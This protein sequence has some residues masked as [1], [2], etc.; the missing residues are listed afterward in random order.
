[1][2]R[3]RT[4]CEL[5]RV[6]GVDARLD[7]PAAAQRRDWPVWMM[8]QVRE[9]DFVLVVASPAYRLRA[10]GRSSPGAGRGVQFEASLIREEFYRNSTIGTTKFLPVL[11][12]GCSVADVPMFLSPTAA[13]C[14]RIDEV[15]PSGIEDLYRVL[16]GQPREIPGPLGPV[17]A[18]PPRPTSH[19]SRLDDDVPG[20]PEPSYA[21]GLRFDSGVT[22]LPFYLVVD[23]SYPMR[24]QNIMAVN[25]ILPQ[26]ADTLAM[27]PI[28]NDKVRLGLISFSDDADVL[29]PLCDLA[30]QRLLPRV[31]SGGS[32]RFAPVFE[33]ARLQ[34]DRDFSMLRSDGHRLH[35]PVLFFVACGP[36][37][38]PPSRWRR[39]FASLTD[40]ARRG[41]GPMVIPFGVDA[42]DVAV[43]RQLVHP[44]D[45]SHLY[46]AV[47]GD[48]PANALR[49]LA[50]ALISS[51]IDSGG[52][53]GGPS[54]I[55]PSIVLPGFAEIP[56]VDPE[57]IV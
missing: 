43:M 46:M 41:R 15:S 39:A 22:L 27:N 6:Q 54:L 7:L 5:L 28:L 21:T 4:L 50:D 37:D 42:A 11:L 3:V 9:S 1:M 23:C 38:D 55:P 30:D 18:Y 52:E 33:L 35:R 49:S 19:P 32:R 53:P 56:L 57:D 34:I 12:P 2:D 31:M 26:V 8:E 29:L 44:A 24:G 51:V 13:T 48:T 45:R 20:G 36:P 16:T 40:V 14:Y 10:E 17:R 47:R 25:Q